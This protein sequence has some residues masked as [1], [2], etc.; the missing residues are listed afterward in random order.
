[1]ACG[2]LGELGSPGSAATSLLSEPSCLFFLGPFLP[3]HTMMCLL[4][5]VFISSFPDTGHNLQPFLLGR[6]AIVFLSKLQTRA[7]TTHVD[8]AWEPQTTTMLWQSC[9]LSAP[10]EKDVLIP[11]LLVRVSGG[12]VT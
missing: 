12:L 11:H 10:T 5:C 3:A 7:I 2:F 4:R 9:H 6:S 1:M 8:I